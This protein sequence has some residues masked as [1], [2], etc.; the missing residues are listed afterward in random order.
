MSVKQE[1]IDFIRRRDDKEG[2]AWSDR[3][4]GVAEAMEEYVNEH[5]QEI[6]EIIERGTVNRRHYKMWEL[7]VLQMCDKFEGE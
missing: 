3:T 2:P 4:E 1:T 7:Q 5:L 6:K